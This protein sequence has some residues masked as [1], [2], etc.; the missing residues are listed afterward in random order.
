V[1]KLK[2]Q[3]TPGAA[4]QS[5]LEPHIARIYAKPGVRVLG[6]L[7]LKHEERSQAAPES[8]KT[9]S[10]TMKITHLEIPTRDQEGV[11]RE[12]MRTLY[13]QRT[14]RGTLDEDGQLTL[15][16]Q[17]LQLAAGQLSLIDS[18][19]LRAAMNHWADY[20]SRVNATAKLTET[21]LRHELGNI[22]DGLRAALNGILDSNA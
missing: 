18:A 5:A 15:D 20:G 7:E 3:G 22:V 14:A 10:V 16:E 12:A 19:S 21:E 8:D 17:S 13:L 9:D 2:I 1:T 6:V 11:L 4:A